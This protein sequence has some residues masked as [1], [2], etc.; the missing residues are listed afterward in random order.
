[1]SFFGSQGLHQ[2]HKLHQNKQA[3]KASL[4]FCIIVV[5]SIGLSSA[6]IIQII[7]DMIQSNLPKLNAMLTTTIPDSFGDCNSNNPTQP[8]EC[9]VGCAD[10]YFK[11]KSWVYEAY[12]RWIS[13]LRT[14]NV[15]SIVF[16]DLNNVITVD[17][18]GYFGNLPLSLWVG[19]CLTFNKCVKIWDNTAGCCGTNKKFQ[20]NITL[21]CQNTYPWLNNIK[22]SDLSLDKFENNRKNYWRQCRCCRHHQQYRSC[23]FWVINNLHHH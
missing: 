23:C 12:A 14:I 2:K 9:S 10:L 4:I 5:C 1:M 6:G 20:V 15:T 17:I 19:E 18:M 11:H 16:S 7:N 13:G 22:L 8:C 3:M 21:D